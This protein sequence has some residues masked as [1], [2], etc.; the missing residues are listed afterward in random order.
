LKQL[1]LSASGKYYGVQTVGDL[2]DALST[3][4]RDVSVVQSYHIKSESK[5]YYDKL[6]LL[7]ALLFAAAWFIRRIYLQEF[8]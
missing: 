6:V 3:I 7:S 5:R 2:A 8:V 4:G 1:A